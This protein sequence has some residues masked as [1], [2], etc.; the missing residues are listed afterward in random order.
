MEK[1]VAQYFPD[2][3]DYSP[4]FIMRDGSTAEKILDWPEIA[5]MDLIIVGKK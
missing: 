5:E 2:Y 1:T 4:G 3:K